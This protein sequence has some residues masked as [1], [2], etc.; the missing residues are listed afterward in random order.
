M[1]KIEFIFT[2]NNDETVDISCK[3]KPS[4]TATENESKIAIRLMQAVK[5]ILEKENIKIEKGEKEN[6]K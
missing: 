1:Q 2:D 3:V 5:Q 4:K 6:G